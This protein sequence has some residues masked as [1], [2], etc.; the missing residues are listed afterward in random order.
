MGKKDKKDKKIEEEIPVIKELP[1]E[2]K[3]KN[4]KGKRRGDSSSEDEKVT[5]PIIKEDNKKNNKKENKKE[6]KREII[7]SEDDKEIKQK[8]EIDPDEDL[9]VHE[10]IKVQKDLIIENVSIMYPKKELLTN[11]D[12]KL[13]MG[14]RIY[15]LIGI[16]GSGKTTLLKTITTG[17]FTDKKIDVSTYD[18]FYV[19]QEVVAST[20]KTVY[21]TV[22]EANYKIYF[23]ITKL[24]ETE[25]LMDENPDDE[26][27]ANRYNKIQN[28][29]VE[30]EYDKQEAEVRKILHGMGFE[31][32]IQNKTTS[33]FSGGWR[34]RI[35]LAKALYMSPMYLF[36]DEP[37]NHLDLETVIWLQEYLKEYKHTIVVISHNQGFLNEVCTD[38]IHINESKLNY[39]IGNYTKFVKAYEDNEKHL[40][41][42]WNKIQKRVKEMQSK[43][44]PKKDVDEFIRKSGVKKPPMPYR[45]RISLYDVDELNGNLLSLDNIKFGYTEDKILFDNLDFGIDSK[46]R[47]TIVGLNGV[48]KSTLLKLMNCDIKPLSGEVIQHNKLR[49]GYFNQHSHEKLPENLTPIQYVKTLGDIND[50]DACKLIGTIGLGG[51][52]KQK[53]ESMSGGQ[54]ARLSLLEF[55]VKKPHLLLL[56]EPTNHLD[57]ESIESL[58][59]AI[60]DF[61]GAVI[62][63]SHDVDLI[64]ETNCVLYELEDGRLNR[65]EFDD[66]VEKI[67]E[68]RKV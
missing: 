53:I 62:I 45:V 68:N 57:I 47:V 65:T 20:T 28:K 60:N 50:H 2:S 12:I 23:L 55:Y 15:G 32:N 17:D 40:E 34:M 56:D 24:E 36:L 31:K 43:S 7:L 49:T 52:M 58:I 38:I 66:Y 6:K 42:E 19:E 25:K 11:T 18:I 64:T 63:I 37:T 5:Q 29:L 13:G 30:L 39:Y 33:E 27:L 3:R 9:N 54:K 21:Q 46:S 16:N 14:G 41:S 67:L 44:T 8:D 61:A 35:S 26:K 10:I 4:K 48:G 22:L 1:V 59:N 51:C